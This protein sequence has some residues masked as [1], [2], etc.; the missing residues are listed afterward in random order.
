MVMVAFSV[1]MTVV[2]LNFHH[3]TYETHE[4]N[5]MVSKRVIS[6]YDCMTAVTA[7]H[8]LCLLRLDLTAII[9]GTDE[10]HYVGLVALDIA[11]GEA[12]H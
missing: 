4:M 5:N 10:G 2:V 12:R 3:R 9:N 7:V 8:R 6:L 11:D 1:V